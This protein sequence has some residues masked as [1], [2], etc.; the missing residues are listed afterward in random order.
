MSGS[1][2]SVPTITTDPRISHETDVTVSSDLGDSTGGRRRNSHR[3]L[4]LAPLLERTG[5]LFARTEI[6]S[7]RPEPLD[8]SIHVSCRCTS[9]SVL[10]DVFLSL[11]ALG[12]TSS[13]ACA[14]RGWSAAG[15]LEATGRLDF[16][17][18]TGSGSAPVAV[19]A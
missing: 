2:S 10:R 16:V 15:C 19:R 7:Y 5:R 1:P 6:V 18:T 9:F 12:G 3:T 14:R 17:R 13:A 11:I 8:S 4:T